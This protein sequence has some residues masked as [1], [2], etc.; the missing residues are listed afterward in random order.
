M[1]IKIT[2]K[3]VYTTRPNTHKVCRL[4]GNAYF[5]RATLLKGETAE[6]FTE[7]RNEDIPTE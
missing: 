6:S 1:A 5:T 4:A 7:V 2:E 3:E